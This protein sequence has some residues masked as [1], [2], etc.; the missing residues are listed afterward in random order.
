[1]RSVLNA[2]LRNQDLDDERL[3]TV[4]CEAEAIV[5]G[6]PLT[7][8]SDS[9]SDFEPLTPNHLLLLRGSAP[10]I[11]GHFTKDDKYSRRWRHVQYLAD[12]FW[13]RW[14]KEYLPTL[15]LRDK[16]IEIKRNLKENDIVLILDEATPRLAWPLGR[17]LK[18]LPGRDG[19][20]RSA[21][22]KTKGTV[23]T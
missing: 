16:W 12:V 9:P 10:T 11:P 4:F 3:E 21:V 13:K 19:L 1:V 7:P 2:V 23:L 8:V 18:T 15:Q 20:V 6:R 17:V 14:I 22:V 5:N